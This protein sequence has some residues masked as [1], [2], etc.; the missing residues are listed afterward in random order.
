MNPVK[1]E[2]LHFKVIRLE[3][4]E[5]R[6]KRSMAKVFGT[7]ICV[8]G[9]ISMALFKGPKLMSTN[10]P[11]IIS[12]IYASGDEWKLGCFFLLCSSSCWAIWLILQVS[13]AL[14]TKTNEIYKALKFYVLSIF[15]GSNMWKSSWS[16]VFI[17]L[18][19][20]LVILAIG[21]ICILF[22]AR[23]ESMEAKL[24]LWVHVLF[25]CRKCKS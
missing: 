7:I 19:V 12:S 21:C 6:S 9:A 14:I 10:S 16:I 24:C 18:D 15:T 11:T 3:K 25:I 23:L 22:G 4:M 13:R 2:I 1:N 20:L 5:I 17:K 8:A